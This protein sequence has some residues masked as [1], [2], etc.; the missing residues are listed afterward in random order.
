MLSSLPFGYRRHACPGRWFAAQTMKQALASIVMNY[1]VE[2]VGKPVQR[3]SLLKTMVPPVDAK[4]RIRRK[5]CGGVA[6]V[7]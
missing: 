3:R 4:I 2:L 5:V 1:N 6:V 7:L